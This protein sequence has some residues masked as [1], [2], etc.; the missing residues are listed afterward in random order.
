M[1]I[2]PVAD[3]DLTILYV[4]DYEVPLTALPD[5]DEP[6]M[7]LVVRGEEFDYMRSVPVKGHGATMPPLLDDWSGEG[8][9]VVAAHRMGRYYLYATA[10][11]AP[12][13]PAEATAEA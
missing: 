2:Q 11:P 13:K 3:D 4:G 12:A 10:A 8:R 9:D 5:D 1:D 7:T 6:P